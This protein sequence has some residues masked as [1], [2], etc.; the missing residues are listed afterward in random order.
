VVC[1]RRHT[2]FEGERTPNLPDATASFHGMS[3]ASATRDNVARAAVEGML[4][5]L[6]EGLDAIRSV[7]AET[8]RVILIGGAVQ[9]AALQRIAAQV[10]KIPVIT[11][12]AGEYVTR[13]AAFQAAWAHSG[14]A[15]HWAMNV[16]AIPEPDF[17]RLIREQYRAACALPTTRNPRLPSLAL[18]WRGGVR[19]CAELK[20]APDLLL[21]LRSCPGWDC[22]ASVALLRAEPAVHGV[23]TDATV[24]R[25]IEVLVT[26]AP[27]RA[28]LKAIDVARSTAHSVRGHT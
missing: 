5:G 16:A 20:G 12:A 27:R 21:R 26:D 23:A 8:K 13:G 6:V 7:G 11:P 1:C 10:F 4:C 25:T 9:N 24:S 14:T 19:P 2:Y 18:S 3:I 28:A 15:P 22:L 17:R